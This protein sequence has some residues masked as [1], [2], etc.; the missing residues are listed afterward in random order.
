MEN[1]SITL[2]ITAC[3]NPGTMIN[4][5]LLDCNLREC[6]YK[7]VLKH[8]LENTTYDIVFVENSNTD[9]SDE[10]L[11]YINEGRLEYI[12]YQQNHNCVEQGKG[13]AEALMIK[14][15]FE[16]SKKLNKS[17]YIIKMTGRLKIKNFSRIL[18]QIRYKLNKQ[19]KYVIAQI[20]NKYDF[21]D[22]QFFIAH[23]EYYEKYLL[24][25]PHLID[26]KKHF[27]IEHKAALDIKK[28]TDSGNKFCIFFEPIWI[29]GMSG[30][31]GKEYK[32]PNFKL[33][34]SNIRSL[35]LF[36]VKN[37]L[38]KFNLKKSWY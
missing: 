15:A 13:Y 4:T 1:K 10:F 7:N 29:E 28:W 27:Y 24:I 32:K 6:Q 2:L 19:N 22:T 35:I 37:A 8:Y 23:K 38:W 30:S 31:T 12:T 20:R 9:F 36:Y 21:V 17:K 18:R 14:H 3:V 11:N 16:I 5:Y 33:Y 25:N 34:L 26:E